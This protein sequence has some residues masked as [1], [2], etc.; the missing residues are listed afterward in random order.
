MQHPKLLTNLHWRMEPRLHAQS[1]CLATIAFWTHLIPAE[2]RTVGSPH[3]PC[4]SRSWPRHSLRSWAALGPK[5]SLRS[6]GGLDPR[7]SHTLTGPAVARHLFR[8]PRSL[9]RS[10]LFL[11]LKN[12]DGTS[13]DGI[14][15]IGFNRRADQC[16]LS[17]AKACIWIAAG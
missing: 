3:R 12:F 11:C 14:F 13:P 10:G 16:L 5:R 1:V 8:K 15:A 6:R 9:I 17:S 7:R 4:E 2:R